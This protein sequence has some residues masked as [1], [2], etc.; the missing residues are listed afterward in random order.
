MLLDQVLQLLQVLS[1]LDLPSAAAAAAAAVSASFE[2]V[3]LNPGNGCL[4][5]GSYHML[6]YQSCCMTPIQAH[7]CSHLSAG[8]GYS[9]HWLLQGHL[10][11]NTSMAQC[12][13]YIMLQDQQKSQSQLRLV[14][15]GAVYNV[16]SGMRVAIV[17][18]SLP[19]IPADPQHCQ[20]Y[21][22][23]H[24]THGRHVL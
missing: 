14:S 1:T 16:S 15:A 20:C 22:W 5:R 2:F 7:A 17:L 18:F 6:A 11:S 10:S 13:R 21:C 8:G 3:Q 12:Y 24:H 9:R 23:L 19:E 4:S